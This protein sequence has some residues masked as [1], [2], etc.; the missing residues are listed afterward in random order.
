MELS[1]LKTIQMTIDDQLLKAV[2]KLTRRRKSTRSAFIR[3]AVE[4]E[5]RREQVRELEIRHADG[6]LR[7]PVARG[8]FDVWTDEQ[9]WGT[10]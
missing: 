9:E 6:Y 5:I 4:A 10:Q 7:K 3:H 1:F 8:E 2:D